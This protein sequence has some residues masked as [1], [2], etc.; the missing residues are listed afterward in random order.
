L[1][2]VEELTDELRQAERS[3]YEKLIR[4]MAR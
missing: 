2:L 4:V 3:A 1:V